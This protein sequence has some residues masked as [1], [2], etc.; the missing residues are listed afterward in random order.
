MSQLTPMRIDG[1][2]VST[3]EESVVRSPFDGREL[4]RVPV[5]TVTEIDQAVSVALARHRAGA[6]PI[7]R[8]AE[9]LDRAAV[10]LDERHEEFAQ[11]ISAESAKPIKTARVEAFR[12]VDTF[13][14]AAAAARTLAGEVIPMDASAAGLAKLGFTIRVPVGVVGAISPFN[15]PLNLVAHKVAPAIATGCPVVLKPASATPLTALLLAQV[16]EEDAEL[17]PGWLN[18]VTAPG[19]VADRLVTH[20]DVAAITF[21]GSPTCGMGDP[22][23]RTSQACGPGAG[24]QRSRDRP[25]GRGRRRGCR[26]DHHRRV[27]LFGPDLHLGATGVRTPIR[28]PRTSP[29]S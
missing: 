4:G 2:A 7:H 18:V 11:S 16:L 6:L 24:Q 29:R 26:S 10:A 15:F 20:D 3:A 28:S 23:A 13:R 14:F 9:I 19:K 17:P 27:L 5:A 22:G 1:H 12:S 21:T 8:R 25:S